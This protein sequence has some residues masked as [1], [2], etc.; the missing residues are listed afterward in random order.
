MGVLIA[1]GLASGLGLHALSGPATAQRQ[2]APTVHTLEQLT[3]AASQYNPGIRAADHAID[4]AE[5]RLDEIRFSPF[6]QFS[7]MAQLFASTVCMASSTRL[8]SS[9]LRPTFKG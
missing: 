8:I 7:G 4:A 1:L 9:M 5:A 6:F 3:Q 2:P